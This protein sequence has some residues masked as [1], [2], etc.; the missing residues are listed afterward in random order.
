MLE[1]IT[2]NMP[3]F[4]QLLRLVDK[5]YQV[6][7]L[8]QSSRAGQSSVDSLLQDPTAWRLMMDW[9]EDKIGYG[10]LD[11]KMHEY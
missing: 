4:W 8:Y 6:D 11:A 1:D 5:S 3:Q 2:Y 10:E 7:L 9:A